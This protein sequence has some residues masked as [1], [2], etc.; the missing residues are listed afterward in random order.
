MRALGIRVSPDSAEKERRLLSGLGLLERRLR[1]LRVEGWVVFPVTGYPQAGSAGEQCVADFEEALHRPGFREVVEIPAELRKSLP[2]SFDIVGTKALIKIPAELEEYGEALGSAI[3]RANTSVDGVFADS[4]VAGEYRLR[5]LR[6]IAGTGATETEV[7]EYGIRLRLDVSRTF[8]SPRLAVERRRVCST[9]VSGETVLDMFA[10][11]G[12]FSIQAAKY[13]FPGRVVSIDINPYAVSY[14]K[15]NAEI[16]RTPNVEAH[17][18]DASDFSGGPF[19]RVIMNLPSGGAS[20]LGHAQSLLSEGGSI[21]YY[22]LIEDAELQRR[23]TGLLSAGL[24]P[25]N[26]RKIKSYSPSQ[27]IYHFTLRRLT[28]LRAQA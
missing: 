6:P 21:E 22:E 2:S 14:L 18:R 9:I 24:A 16:N 12:P 13:A 23:C 27:G 25:G 15:E 8:Y 28:S 10:G 20:F 5:R 4:G 11:V 17:L 7:T 19:D 3:L 26:I 1:T